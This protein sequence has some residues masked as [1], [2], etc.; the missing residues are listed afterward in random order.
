M[1][2]ISTSFFEVLGVRMSNF[3]FNDMKNLLLV[4]MIL[5]AGACRNDSSGEYMAFGEADMEFDLSE[6]NQSW[7]L[8]NQRAEKKGYTAPA[9]NLDQ[10][11]TQSLLS[12]IQRSYEN[13]ANCAHRHRDTHGRSGSRTRSAMGISMSMCSIRVIFILF[14]QVLLFYFAIY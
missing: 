12:T 3:G 2:L 4:L 11:N 10:Q 8:F 6:D 5:L 9:L 1:D 7:E 14:L 13:H